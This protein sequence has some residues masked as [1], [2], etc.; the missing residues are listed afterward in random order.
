MKKIYLFLFT[1]IFFSL[2][3]NAQDKKGKEKIRALKIAYLTEKL[4]L[5]STESEKFWPLFNDYHKKRRELFSFEKHEIKD[6]IKNGY[7]INDLSNKE[8]ETILTKIVN[9]REQLY[10]NKISFHKKL[11]AI[12]PAKKILV[13]EITER[14]FNKKLMHKLKNKTDH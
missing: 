1:V 12:L 7:D 3:I 14:E 13:L 5:T 4:D 8:A 2:T 11:H 6:R 10:K 9:N